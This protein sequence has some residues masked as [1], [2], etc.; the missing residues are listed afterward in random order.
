MFRLSAFSRL[1]AVAAACAVSV[2][3]AAQ[4]PPPTEVQSSPIAGWTFRP[5]IAIA[6]TYDSNVAITTAPASTGETPSDTMLSINP[7]GALKYYGKRTV[8]DADYRGTIRRY[9][10]LSG[11]NGYD[12]HMSARIERRAT[13]R[14][15]IFA[16]NTFSAVPTTDELELNGA[17][18]KRAGSRHDALAGGMAFRLTAYDTLSARYDF[19]WVDFDR[20]EPELT[21]GIING[22]HS[23]LSHAL[24]DRLSVGGEGSYRFANMDV[25]GGR[26]LRFVDLGGI[27][28]YR[29]NESTRLSAAAGWG[30]LNDLLLNTTRSGVYVRGSLTRVALQSVFGLSYERS[31]LPSFG[32]GGSNRS[33]EVRSWVDLPPIGRRVFTQASAAWRRTDPFQLNELQLDTIYIRGTAGYALSRWMRA[34]G[35]YLFTRQDSIVTGGEINRHRVGGEIVLSQPVRIR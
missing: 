1:V 34:Q 16:Q 19:T 17:P 11:L 14:L 4:Q 13:K 27:V 20:N 31:F 10:E 32:F 12:Q 28:N 5:G 33:Q 3:V 21:G 6:T 2:T 22:V 7:V 35:F 23:E 8:F 15:T 9:Q 24:T 25:D 29:L 26:R 18:F 30:H